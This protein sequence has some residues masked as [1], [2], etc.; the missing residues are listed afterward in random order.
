MS[1]R[2]KRLKTS[3]KYPSGSAAMARWRP[4][5]GGTHRRD[6]GEAHSPPRPRRHCGRHHAP[7]SSTCVLEGAPGWV[8]RGLSRRPR[9]PPT[10]LLARRHRHRG[11]LRLPRG[12]PAAT[13]PL[14]SPP[15]TTTTP[16]PAATI[17]LAA[18][19]PSAGTLAPPPCPPPWPPPSLPSPLPPTATPATPF[20]R[21]RRRPFPLQSR[22][23][24]RRARPALTGGVCQ[25]TADRPTGRWAVRAVVGVGR[26]GP[27]WM[28]TGVR[29]RCCRSRR[30]RHTVPRAS[31]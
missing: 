11:T 13:G 27:A 5:G 19:V 15:A 4:W 30:R 3:H 29:R 6:D 16:P 7:T 14:P 12:V 25:P 8:A 10:R 22:R 23:T 28:T 24:P 2:S 20:G 17:P 31:Q 1:A 18:T 21:F 26:S 9:P